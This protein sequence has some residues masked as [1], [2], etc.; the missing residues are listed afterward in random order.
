MIQS[1]A[2]AAIAEKVSSNTTK[3]L[4]QAVRAKIPPRQAA[5]ATAVG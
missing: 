3:L 5:E 1:I 2:F 4:E